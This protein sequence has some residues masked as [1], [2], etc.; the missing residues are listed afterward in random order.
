MSQVLLG[1]G[2]NDLGGTLMN[3]SI[4]TAAG[5]F[6]PLPKHSSLFVLHLYSS[7]LDAVVLNLFFF[8]EFFSYFIVFYCFYLICRAIIAVRTYTLHTSSRLHAPLINL[9]V[10]D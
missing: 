8:I 5:P 10:I 9:R 1:C 2:V 4:S 7:S 6:P 3:E